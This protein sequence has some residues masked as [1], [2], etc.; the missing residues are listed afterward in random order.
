[1]TGYENGNGNGI[2]LT[3]EQIRM[4]EAAVREAEGEGDVLLGYDATGKLRVAIEE[5]VTR[6][7]PLALGPYRARRE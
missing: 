2:R 3:R 1:M 4:L 7:R 6:A 5:V